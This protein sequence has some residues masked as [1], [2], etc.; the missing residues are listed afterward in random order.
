MK[1]IILAAGKSSRLY[2]I[3]LNKPKCLLNVHG[4]K[5][6]EHQIELLRLC[7]IDDILV[8]TG[9]LHEKIEKILGEKVRYKYYDRY[10]KTNNMHTLHSV[11]NELDEDV[12]ILFS[13]VLLSKKILARCIEN[14]D[15]YSLIIDTDNI[16]INTM[17]VIINSASIKEIGNQIDLDNASGNFIGVAKYSRNGATVLKNHIEKLVKNGKGLDD[18]YTAALNKISAE[19]ININYV[20]TNKSPWIEIDFEED[21]NDL[22]KRDISEF[23][24]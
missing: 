21:Y 13:D 2:P 24:S 16:S 7:G 17:R 14:E 1:A 23:Y 6:I 10:K 8:V 9:Y 4:K 3:T 22:L 12:I 20:D 11:R 15:D 18:Y 5:L 19:N